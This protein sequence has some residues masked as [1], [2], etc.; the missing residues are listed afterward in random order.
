MTC[1][2]FGILILVFFVMETLTMKYKIAILTE[3]LC[4]EQKRNELDEILVGAV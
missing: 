1:T 2:N 4:A 3:I